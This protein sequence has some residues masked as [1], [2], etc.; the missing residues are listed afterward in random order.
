M[1]P[2]SSFGQFTQATSE[3]VKLSVSANLS[4]GSS[5]VISVLSDS[6]PFALMAWTE[7]CVLYGSS[8]NSSISQSLR[9]FCT[10][11]THMVAYSSA[12]SLLRLREVVR[13][14]KSKIS[15]LTR[16]D[17][18][19]SKSVTC[20]LRLSRRGKVASSVHCNIC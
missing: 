3:R 16:C 20:V 1:L 9:Q 10:I 17:V 11:R 19:N 12:S 6:W 15:R 2:A 14:H 8:I 5:R 7:C 4:D 13:N 18:C